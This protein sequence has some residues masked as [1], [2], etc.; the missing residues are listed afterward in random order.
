MLFPD[1][2][3][4]YCFFVVFIL[5]L[6]FSLPFVC[7]LCGAFFPYFFKLL[8]FQLISSFYFKQV[9]HNFQTFLN[10]RNI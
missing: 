10:P 6:K 1:V 7:F 4:F 2:L 3:N 5:I 9:K 8:S